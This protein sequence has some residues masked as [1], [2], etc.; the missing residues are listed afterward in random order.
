MITATPGATTSARVRP[1]RCWPCSPGASSSSRR[2]ISFWRGTHRIQGAARLG[3]TEPPNGWIAL[4]LYLLLG[5]AFP[6]YLQYYLN[7]VWQS[8]ADPLPGQGSP[9]AIPDAMPPRLE[10]EPE[11]QAEPSGPTDGQS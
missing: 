9:P 6:A 10:Q 7:Q 1:I 11:R 4:I 8:D 3:R 2:L 5:I